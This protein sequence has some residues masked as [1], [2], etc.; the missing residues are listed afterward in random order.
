MPVH[1][2]DQNITIF[3]SAIFQTTSTVAV[4][5]EAVI[6]IDPT[7]LPEEI[8]EIQNHVAS[9]SKDRKQYLVFT[10][11][12][13]DHIL[14]CHAFPE[15]VTIAS[16]PF[17]S[18]PKKEEKI[19]E[20]KEFDDSYFIVRPYEIGYP[21]IDIVIDNDEQVIEIGSQTLTF[22]LAPGHNA[23]GMFILIDHLGVLIIGDYLSDVEIPYI[24]Q[25]TEFYEESLQ[26][27]KSLHEQ[28]RI[29]VLIP[30]HGSVTSSPT[31]I[32]DRLDDS[33]WY[34][35]QLLRT[36]EEDSKDHILKSFVDGYA[37][38]TFMKK[39][40]QENIELVKREKASKVKDSRVRE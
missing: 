19:R 7:L 31:E 37:F 6:I 39:V 40:H 15:A 24:H 13:Y 5:E 1:Y 9:V 20:I 8:T 12:D 17:V 26:K 25:N 28:H 3:Q 23:D 35:E 27:I 38:S 16:R 32:K 29:N 36:A 33:L 22:Y 10:H 34:I 2:Q 11:S 14:G 18:N 21:H 30:G 4:T